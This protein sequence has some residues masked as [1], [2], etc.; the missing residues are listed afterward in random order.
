MNPGVE[1]KKL[2]LR[3]SGTCKVCGKELAKGS[4]GY[5]F[6]TEKKVA[7]TPCVEAHSV[8]GVDTT[9]SAGAS[10]QREFDRRSQAREQHLVDQWGTLGRVAAAI[11]DDPQTTRAWSNGAKGERKVADHLEKKLAGSPCRILHDRQRRGQ[12]NFDHLVVG[13]AGVT[14]IDTKEIVGNVR[15]VSHGFGKRSAGFR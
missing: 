3:Y 6:K 2:T 8:K 12:A 14:V 9:S 5:H 10:A 15:A 11:T 7:C 1:A 13:P 4:V